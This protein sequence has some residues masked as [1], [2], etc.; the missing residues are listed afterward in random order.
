M[1][2]MI[3]TNP[4]PKAP[5]APSFLTYSLITSLTYLIHIILLILYVPYLLLLHVFTA[6]PF[7]SWTLALRLSTRM[8]KMRTSLI[9]WW[10]PPKEYDD[11]TIFPPGEEYV[12]SMEKGEVD[13][14][15]VKLAPVPDEMR[16]GLGRVEGVIGEERPGFWIDPRGS[17]ASKRREEAEEIGLLSGEMSVGE[18]VIL[19]IHGGSYIRG[20][21][22]WTTFPLDIAKLTGS[23]CLTVSYRKTLS[24]SAAFPAPLLDV[25]SAYIYLTRTISIP[26]TQIIILAESAGAHLAILLSQY[27]RDLSLPQPGCFALSS[28]WCDFTL[29]SPSYR[30]NA[31]YDQLCPLRLRRAVKSATRWYHPSWLEREEG[32]AYFSPAR[33]RDPEV[34]WRYL[35]EQGVK[36]YMQYGGRELFRD[37][38]VTLGEGMRNAGV[39]VVVREHVDGLHTGGLSVPD[40]KKAFQ[41]DVLEML[42]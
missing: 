42:R 37:E 5:N 9:A 22:L 13:I 18:R 36:V 35:K 28:P 33:V 29:S 7:E 41:K 11:W 27:L 14:E 40:A 1:T 15:V 2:Q 34:H 23:R 26:S 31:A 20:H 25:F 12:K 10:I 8:T 16:I 21:P 4:D 32:L 17:S 39:D 30:T 38:I 6:P 19:H 24:S 3:R